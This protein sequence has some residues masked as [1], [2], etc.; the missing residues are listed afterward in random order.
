MLNCLQVKDILCG[1]PEERTDETNA[2]LA[3]FGKRVHDVSFFV[4]LNGDFGANVIYWSQ[5]VPAAIEAKCEEYAEQ[6][7]GTEPIFI[8][9][10]SESERTWAY[11]AISHMVKLSEKNIEN[12]KSTGNG[13]AY[14]TETK[15]RDI[16]ANLIKRFEPDKK[17]E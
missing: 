1:T 11:N 8:A 9:V 16:Y 5:D 12:S 13:E 17:E 7:P 2:V 10:M 4:G 14:I 6:N 3:F 15:E